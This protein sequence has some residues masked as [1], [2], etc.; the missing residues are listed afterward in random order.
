[1]TMELLPSD[2]EEQAALQRITAALGG[3]SGGARPAAD[4]QA[5]VLA[6]VRQEAAAKAA[7]AAQEKLD[8]EAQLALGWKHAIPTLAAAAIMLLWWG[9]WRSAQLPRQLEVEMEAST[10]VRRGERDGGS[11]ANL[12]S[13]VTVAAVSDAPYRAVWVF[14]G[15][16]AL[17][18]SCPGRGCSSTES[19][20]SA[21]LT[22]DLVGEYT[23]V[24]LWSEQ[25][26]PTP[27]ADRD[28]ALAAAARAGATVQS[29]KFRVW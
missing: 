18:L 24:A 22:I 12:G 8:E 28:A 11:A 9:P 3:M 13:R 6:K 25:P 26:L 4:W 1:M 17:A 27:G 23:V 21:A 29:Q 19:R 20:L 2:P 10:V 5:R 16:D 14:R 15:R 7:A